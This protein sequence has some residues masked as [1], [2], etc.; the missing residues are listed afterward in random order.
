MTGRHPGMIDRARTGG[1]VVAQL[2]RS[3]G[4]CLSPEERV[5]SKGGGATKNVADRSCVFGG[6]A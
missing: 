3:S 1:A 5:G 2:I 4:W 6:T